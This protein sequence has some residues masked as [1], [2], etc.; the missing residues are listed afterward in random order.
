MTAN[1][2]L[3]VL[4]L[5]KQNKEKKMGFCALT[6]H[7][8]KEKSIAALHIWRVLRAL[9]F[10]LVNEFDFENLRTPRVVVIAG[11]CNATIHGIIDTSYGWEI[12]D[13]F[14]FYFFFNFL[15]LWALKSICKNNCNQLQAGTYV[16]QS[17]TSL[18]FKFIS[19][20]I[21]FIVYKRDSFVF[22]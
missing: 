10:E 22:G 11:T 3:Y 15:Q 13:F 4:V 17:K 8:I 1:L 7:S 18:A 14:E 5:Q 12:L 20:T 21:L 19:V 6:K 9:W 2:F 16:C